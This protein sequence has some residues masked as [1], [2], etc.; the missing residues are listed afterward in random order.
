MHDFIPATRD[1]FSI[2]RALHVSPCLAFRVRWD[3]EAENLVQDDT[4]VDGITVCKPS[5]CAWDEVF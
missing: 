5:L 4:R 2:E 1:I 3:G